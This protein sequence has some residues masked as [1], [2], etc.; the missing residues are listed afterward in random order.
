MPVGMRSGH[1]RETAGGVDAHGRTLVQAG[2]RAEL[3]DQVRRRDPAGLDIAGDPETAQAALRLA[4]LAPRGKAVEIGDLPELVHRGMIIAGVVFHRHRRG[5][6]KF[7][8]EVLT[9]PGNRIEPELQRR[10]VDDALELIGRLGPSRPAIGVDR[11]GVGEHRPDVHVDQRRAVI[12]GHQRAVQ[13]GRDRRREGAEICAHIGMR[14]G[15]D[16]GEIVVGIERQFDPGDM[17]APVRVRHER[18]RARRG[19]LDRPVERARGK[20]AECLLGI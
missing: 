16:R 12:S 3:S 9:P 10:L 13:P 18:L 5:V 15:A 6:R 7:G 8:D 11:H 14:V 2:A 1:H 20:G 17:V 4:L 19:P